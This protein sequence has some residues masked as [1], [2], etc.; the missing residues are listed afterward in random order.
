MVLHVMIRVDAVVKLKHSMT[1]VK[2]QV[3]Q[4]TVVRQLR[5]IMIHQIWNIHIPV[6]MVFM[7]FNMI[8]SMGDSG[9]KMMEE[10]SGGMELMIGGL[11]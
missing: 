10:V 8:L 4:K 5:F 11:V 6:F 7:K 1:N 9:T 3:G 2:L